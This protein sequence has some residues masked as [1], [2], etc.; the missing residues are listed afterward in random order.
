[1]NRKTFFCIIALTT[2]LL[3]GCGRTN[4]DGTNNSAGS[5]SASDSG[6]ASATESAMPSSTTDATQNADPS[7]SHPQLNTTQN[8]SEN[9]TMISEEK[10]KEIALAHAGLTADQ[11]TFVKSGIDSEDGR[12]EYD[13]EFYTKDRKEYDYEID[14]YSGEVLDY[15]Y[16]AEYHTSTSGSDGTAA[17]KGTTDGSGTTD[18]S[19]TTDGNVTT[20]G[21]TISTEEAKQI[22]LAK[23]PGAT[24][25]DIREFK[26][27]YD[28][29]KL[30]YEGKIYYDKK[31]YEFEIDGSSGTILEWDV[32]SIYGGD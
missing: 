30:Q 7:T 18:S 21:K 26:S 9:G 8:G 13:V 16:D 23:I 17:G 25:E 31:E 10:A 32:E 15:D 20:N 27:D 1:M 2:L 19:S 5:G 12:K 28:N 3:N 29:S 14:A 4:T 24:A 11:V 22:A 6:A